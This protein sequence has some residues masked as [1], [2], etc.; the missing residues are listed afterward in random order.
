MTWTEVDS[1]HA[2]GTWKKQL[3]EKLLKEGRLL[4]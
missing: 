2:Q 4:K 1:L 3:S